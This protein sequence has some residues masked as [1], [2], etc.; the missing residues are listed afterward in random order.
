MSVYSYS[1]I[2][3]PFNLRHTCWFC[4]EPS[5]TFTE[6]P[7]SEESII[8]IDHQPLAIPACK[9]C[10]NVRYKN[11]VHSVWSLRD[12]IKHF[13]ITKYAKHLGIGEN[14]TEKELQESEFS[15]SLL[16]GFGR[17]AWEMYEIAKM[18]VSFAGW[19]LSVDEVP[20]FI[21]DETSGFNFDGVR[22][23]SVSACVDY[24]Q[25]AAGID[26]ALLEGLLDI[27]TTERF[28]YAL[29]I[30]QLNKNVKNRERSEILDE[31]TTQEIEN[32]EVNNQVPQLGFKGSDVQDVV[33][34]G[35]TA[36]TFSIQ[37]AILKGVKTLDDLCAIED[38]YFDEFEH[39]GGPA[40]FASYNGL[41]LYLEARKDPDWVNQND[42]NTK[43]WK[44]NSGPW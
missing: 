5:Y 2:D 24:Y 27:V 16:G 35:T 22:Y 3:V 25:K 20:L 7:I 33:I 30:A 32:E 17:S 38:D 40:A 1:Q 31:I 18:R 8:K 43:Y 13:L 19:E 9:E 26:R 4:G 44:S 10:S 34:N 6:F 15:G 14:W 42:P 28:A 21:H 41:Q 23:L 29:R 36:H 12:H 37:W 11:D 39:L